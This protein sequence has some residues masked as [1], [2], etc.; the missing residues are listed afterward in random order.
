MLSTNV[1]FYSE[2]HIAEAA[3]DLIELDAETKKKKTPAPA[4]VGRFVSC[5]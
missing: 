4:A 3:L 2:S 1:E 5:F